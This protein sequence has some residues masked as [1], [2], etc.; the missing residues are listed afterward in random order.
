MR[1]GDGDDP[2]W[3]WH[4]VVVV[5]VSYS[6]GVS[7]YGVGSLLRIISRFQY[8]D[9]HF[10][11]LTWLN[12]HPDSSV[13]WAGLD[14]QEDFYLHLY[15]PKYYNLFCRWSPVKFNNSWLQPFKIKWVGKWKFSK[16]FSCL[17]L[18]QRNL[19]YISDIYFRNE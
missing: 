5:Y 9:I 12:L 6:G 2:S 7:Q 17:K 8:P 18:R 19:Q 3:K 14:T 10:F 15:L 11:L 16:D 1:T 13:S 4:S